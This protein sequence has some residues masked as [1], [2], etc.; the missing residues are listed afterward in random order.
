MF[1]NLPDELIYRIVNKLDSIEIYYLTLTSKQLNKMNFQAILTGLMFKTYF[2]LDRNEFIEMCEYGYTLGNY[3]SDLSEIN[4]Y[5]MFNYEKKKSIYLEE[6]VMYRFNI[7][8]ENLFE[9]KYLMNVKIHST[10]RI[11]FMDYRLLKIRKSP[12]LALIY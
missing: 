8:Q 9:K 2:D 11:P 5:N 12:I 1:V 6:K 10:Y 3:L 4:S 7:K